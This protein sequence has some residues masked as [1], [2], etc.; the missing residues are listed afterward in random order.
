MYKIYK[1]TSPENKVYIGITSQ[2]KLYDRW[3]YGSGYV[4]NKPLY[5]DILAFGWK[6]FKHELID[7][8]ETHP[9]A[10]KKER[11]YILQFKSN[12][13]EF[14]YNSHTNASSVDK[15]HRYTKCVETGELFETL[16]DAGKKYGR[17]RQAISYAITHGT[18][19]ARYHWEYEWHTRER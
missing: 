12:E 9:E 19:C 13:E 3:Q 8:A 10:I 11:E 16:G 17:T 1:L 7:T 2:E 5:N 15:L 4:A 14:G 18:K 6:N